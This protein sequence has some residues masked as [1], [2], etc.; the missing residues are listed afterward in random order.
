MSFIKETE[1]IGVSKGTIQNRYITCKGVI[2]EKEERGESDI[3][4]DDEVFK[5]GEKGPEKVEKEIKK[6]LTKIIRCAMKLRDLRML[7][8]K[9]KKEMIKIMYLR[10]LRKK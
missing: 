7:S 8:K 4:T 3:D 10:R 6:V 1:E 5:E 9:E 2:N